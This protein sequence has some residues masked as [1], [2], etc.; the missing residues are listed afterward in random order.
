MEAPSAAGCFWRRGI[1]HITISV[2]HPL[3]S[4]VL[5]LPLICQIDLQSRTDLR[6]T[7]IV[8]IGRVGK[9]FRN[10]WSRL[11]NRVE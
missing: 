2:P 11:A 6:F 4:H 8:F 10:E 5:L 1:C 3:P 9:I 7:L